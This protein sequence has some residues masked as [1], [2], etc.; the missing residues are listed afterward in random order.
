MLR[1]LQEIRM[2]ERR[3][4]RRHRDRRDIH[5]RADVADG[6]PFTRLTKRPTDE[7]HDI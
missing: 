3:D 2:F 7:I 6:D 4:Y 1:R 5:F